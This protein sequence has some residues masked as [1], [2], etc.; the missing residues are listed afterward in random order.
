V[1]DPDEI[2]ER[3]RLSVGVT[4]AERTARVRFAPQRVVGRSFESVLAERSS[5]S[6]RTAS[7]FALA[8]RAVRRGL[9]VVPQSSSESG[10]AA[11]QIEFARE[12]SVYNAGAFW[13]LCAP[14]RHFAGRPGDWE[15]HEHEGIRLDE[16]FWLLE[17]IKA[18]VEAFDDGPDW[19]RG[20]ECRRYRGRADFTVAAAAAAATQRPLAR[21]AAGDGVDLTRLAL[22]VWLDPTGRIR[23][24]A[25][26]L[27]GP[28]MTLEL[29]DFG[30]PLPIDL[31][32]PA[33]T[34]PGGRSS[35]A[36]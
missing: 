20:A 15:S 31:P 21:P 34:R 7:A 22:D 26:D 4:A 9:A 27:G 32:D 36:S 14:G 3:I 23:R 17:L 2:V 19:V 5:A 33:E 8:R 29:F 1:S 24:A 10:V 12:R 13:K 11:G 30:E 18:T 16:P 28:Q 25:L 35:G 6:G